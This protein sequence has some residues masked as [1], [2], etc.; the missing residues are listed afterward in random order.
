MN[1]ISITKKQTPNGK[2]I[3]IITICNEK[4]LNVLT[5]EIIKEI[6]NTLKSWQKDD[7][8]ACIVLKGSGEKAFCAG[9]DIKQILSFSTNKNSSPNNIDYFV[10]EYSLDYLIHTYSKPIIVLADGIVMGGGMGLTCGASHRVVTDKTMMAMP[11]IT[12]GLFP[13]VGATYFLNRCPGNTGIF[14][15]LTGARFDGNDAIYTNLAD[16]LVKSSDLE[17][18][19]NSLISNRH[20]NKALEDNSKI[21]DDILSTKNISNKENSKIAQQANEI[22]NLIDIESPENTFKNISTY[23]KDSHLINMGSKICLEGSPLSF[24][25]IFKQITEGKNLSLEDVFRRE[26]DMAVN[27]TRHYEFNEGV[28]ALVIRKDK[29]PNWTHNKIKQVTENDLSEIFTSPWKM[30][31]HPFKNL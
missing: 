7:D 2:Y 18:I 31:E 4:S 20:W 8:F 5:L 9:G 23:N 1:K 22:N 13:D 25:V 17:A 6:L 14:L 12:I 15:G 11:E 27:M 16:Y 24:K 19:I 29:N 28:S 26:L 30:E 21:V 3:G 10:N